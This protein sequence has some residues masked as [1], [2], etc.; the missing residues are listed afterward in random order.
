MR[1]TILTVDDAKAVRTLAENALA[2]FDCDLTTATNGFEAFFAIERTRPD[3]ILLDISMP[4]MGGVET[5]QRLK[6][7]PELAGI[8][9]IM[10]T[11]RADHTVV[12]LLPK[13]GAA[14]H[15]LKPFD[16]ATLLSAIKGVIK[17][18]PVSN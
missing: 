15:V 14:G 11:S 17:L 12:P 6:A 3:L 2:G 7:A 1:P 9:V 8:P 16:E 5:L 10:L 4:I 13:M 18:Q